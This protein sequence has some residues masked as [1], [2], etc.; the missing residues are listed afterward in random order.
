MQSRR[1]G[2]M[3]KG[4]DKGCPYGGWIWW[5]SSNGFASLGGRFPNR[6]YG[7]K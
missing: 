6:P 5:W 1:Y 3:G 4:N 2:L 7:A